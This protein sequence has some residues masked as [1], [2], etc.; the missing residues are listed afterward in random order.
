MTTRDVRQ[1]S[2]H[3]PSGGPAT[4][5]SLEP[6]WL[7]STTGLYAN[8]DLE[9]VYAAPEGA[10]AFA[11]STQTVQ[12]GWWV[13]LENTQPVGFDWQV[14][15]LTVHAP[16]ALSDF[17]PP[18]DAAAGFSYSWDDLTVGPNEVLELRG[19]E[20][21]QVA[22]AYIPLSVTRSFRGNEITGSGELTTTVT[23]IAQAGLAG[24]FQAQVGLYTA[25]GESAWLAGEGFG[26]VA[27]VAAAP[28]E[29]TVE[30]A[31]A[32]FFQEYT[33]HVPD[34]V[35]GQRYIFSC[36]T[37]VELDA[38]V[39][40]ARVEPRVDVGAYLAADAGTESWSADTLLLDN[41]GSVVIDGLNGVCDANPYTHAAWYGVELPQAV[42]LGAPPVTQQ[43]D[44]AS[45]VIT[46]Q[47][48]GLTLVGDGYTLVGS[49]DFAGASRTYALTGR[50]TV[51]GVDCLVLS[52]DGFGA[53]PVQEYYDARIAEDTAG[54]I[55]LLR[56]TGMDGDGQV[57]SWLV[58]APDDAPVFLPGEPAA[59]QPLPWLAGE[60]A[61]I[62]GV[63]EAT[64]ELSTGLGPYEDCIVR[65]WSDGAGE[66]YTW[67]APGAGVVLEEWSDYGGASGQ[68]QRAAPVEPEI[69]WSGQWAVGG[70]T[71]QAGT[72]YAGGY[73]TQFQDHVV[74]TITRQQG[75]L[76]LAD[77]GDPDYAVIAQAT[78]QELHGHRTGV[79]ANGDYYESYL[80]M[81]W[82]DDGVAVLLY[83]EGGYSDEGNWWGSSFAGLG[84]VNAFQ[85]STRPFIGEYDVREF[86]VLVDARGDWDVS[87]AEADRALRISYLE[88]GPYAVYD[89]DDLNAPAPLYVPWS[90]RL[91]RNTAEEADDG[92]Y[93]HWFETFLRGP[94]DSLVYLGH[95]SDF[96][97]PM[98]R[99]L[100]WASFWV[101]YATPRPGFEWQPDLAG[102][103]DMSKVP[104]PVL[105][106]QTFQVP[107]HVLNLGAGPA[108]GKVRIQVYASVDDQLGP[109]DVLLGE[110]DNRP[111]KVS[112]GRFVTYKVG[113][114]IP[115]GMAYGEYHLLAAIDVDDAIAELD[116]TNNVALAEGTLALVEPRRDLAGELGKIT[117]ADVLVP[118]DRGTVAVSVVNTGNIPVAGRIAV[119]V[120][121]SADAELD[122]DTDL[123]IAAVGNQSIKLN[124]GASK[125]YSLRASIPADAPAGTYYI[126]A[127]VDAADAIEEVDEANNV[128]A[129][130]E[131][132]SVSWRFGSF[133]GRKNVKLSVVD[134][135]GTPVTFSMPGA[136]WGEVIGGTAFERVELHETTAKSAF[137]I[138]TRKSVRTNMGDILADGPL[139]EVN[140][141]TAN[142]HGSVGIQGPVTRLVLGDVPAAAEGHVIAVNASM[143]TVGKSTLTV[144]LGAV[145]DLDLAAHGLP[146]RSLT[147]LDWGAGGPAP[148]RIAATRIDKLVTKGRRGRAGTAPL[149]GDLRADLVLGGGAGSKPVL[150]RAV[151]AG[152]ASGSWQILGAA[153]TIKAASA[154]PSWELDVAGGVKAVDVKDALRGELAADYFTK[155][156]TKGEL[157]ADIIARAAEPPRGMSIGTLSAGTVQDVSLHVPAGINA[158]T[159]VDWT[160]P[161][162][163]RDEI[164]ALWIGKL[165]TKGRGGNAR[166]GVEPSNG[167]FQADLILGSPELPARKA[168]LGTVKIAG[169]LSGSLW[170]LTGDAK[171]V[172]VRGA[173]DDWT[174]TADSLRSLTAGDVQKADLVVLDALGTVKVVRWGEGGLQ[175][176]SIKSLKVAGRGGAA[177]VPG[178]F[179]AALT[180]LG[181][182][183]SPKKT[184]LGSAKVAGDLT[185]GLWDVAGHMGPLTVQGTA[186][187][188]TVRTTGDMAKLTLG[189]TEDCRFLA[190]ISREVADHARIAAD[191]TNPEAV[192]KSIQV[193]GRRLPKGDPTRFVIDTTFSA[194]TIV[195]ASL[196]NTNGGE[197]CGLYALAADGREI[198]S[199]KYRETMN[200]EKWTWSSGTGEPPVFGSLALEAISA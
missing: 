168:A 106:D 33:W 26:T 136:G 107:V 42:E 13:A 30:R 63:G 8:F 75:G 51:Y 70:Y 85:T 83:G 88:G 165:T 80:I 94:G 193:R 67:F 181:Q 24:G 57:V 96:D 131:P 97:T 99:D 191:F 118:G 36:T 79:D 160:D 84:A 55:R 46:N 169:G 176:D 47:W 43:F 60:A 144:T 161:L 23:V 122:R 159:V 39:E 133:D 126:L 9:Y 143:G 170:D 14:D 12:P 113:A 73:S 137:R 41:G 93:L 150:G 152:E 68:W 121:L 102:D 34:A 2:R 95:A 171:A 187:G 25:E 125:T 196:I 114:E 69:D 59:G 163:P 164:R 62:D 65:G 61:W 151:L 3:D 6:R 64:P 182:N 172:T 175:A 92:T 195:S 128:V 71:M 158:V 50:E 58:D 178:D 17:T 66:Q 40:W 103:I 192:I 15:R 87:A 45:D 82:V 74:V 200:D 174:A 37:H 116:E 147:A 76:W 153:G 54:N 148:D 52:I 140:A 1:G 135:A 109:G 90:N 89:L 29:G 149:A 105:P 155:I 27:H 138:G 18:P 142:L 115:A 100:W 91:L 98:Q 48:L 188:A 5:E 53:E 189:A 184:S 117:L 11:A 119:G 145:G 111:L 132:V 173:V 123:R 22:D 177:S 167:N 4:M 194:A 7:L 77:P 10:A 139:R 104:N 35:P 197:A 190:G 16:Y 28:S 86:Q 108:E 183:V 180:V 72:S 154:A 112:G 19:F 120:Y 156:S 81:R 32:A 166:L 127:D 78:G 185:T 146:I 38:D 198:R 130:A 44:A 134:V 101:G 49:D 21:G 162:G 110:L 56:L 129:T 31:G 157:A 124:P 179:A 186:R 199:V 20:H 141:P